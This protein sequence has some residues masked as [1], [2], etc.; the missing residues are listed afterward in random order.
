MGE[1]VLGDVEVCE[2][3]FIRARFLLS[4]VEGLA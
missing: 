3:T 1:V 2:L 4:P